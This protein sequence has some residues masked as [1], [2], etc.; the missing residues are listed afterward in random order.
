MET[1]TAYIFGILTVVAIT[2][3]ITAVIGIVKI[4]KQQ[5]TIQS[6]NKELES[7]NLEFHRSISEI[8]QH[9]DNKVHH[10]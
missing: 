10:N 4:L 2:L 5:R 8:Y 6:I 3:V 9:T 1:T 7:N